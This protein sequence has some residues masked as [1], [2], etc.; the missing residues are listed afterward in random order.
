MNPIDAFASARQYLDHIAP[1]WCALPA[2]RRGHFYVPYRLAGRARAAGVTASEL[3]I[4]RAPGSWPPILIAAYADLRDH[5]HRPGILL[6]HGAGQTYSNADPSYPGGEG[7]ESAVLFLCPNGR[8][9]MEN[10]RRYPDAR[11]AVVGCPKL[12]RYTERSQDLGQ[13]CPPVPGDA[14]PHAGGVVA[15]SFHWECRVAPESRSAF[16][17]FRQAVAEL[18]GSGCVQLLGHGHPRAW[19]QL[20]PFWRSIGVEPVSEFEEVLDRADLLVCDNSSAIYEFAATGRPVLLL[21]APWYRRDVEHGLRFWQLA[22]VGLHCSE[23][24]MLQTDVF[25][26]L[27]DP[28]E[29]SQ[30]RRSVVR[31]VYAGLD[32]RAAARAVAAIGTVLDGL[33][34]GRI[35]MPNPYRPRRERQQQAQM[36]RDHESA[37]PPRGTIDRVLAW[38]GT[39]P[40]RAAAAREAEQVASRPRR[41][42][43]EQLDR[44]VD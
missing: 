26:A 39:D 30:R 19:G 2:E 22:D 24:A 5:K 6:E 1:V 36:R 38:V 7:R 31:Q 10:L 34:P 42:L 33:D 41:T 25:R 21:D 17:H 44:I 12:D 18:A 9:A 40:T 15:F 35:E 4:G 14:T 28:A 37:T 23:A 11:T 20:E 16:P 43:L 32:G 27:Q 3:M 29:V 13:C 8:V